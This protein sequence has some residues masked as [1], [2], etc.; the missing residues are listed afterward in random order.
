MIQLDSSTKPKSENDLCLGSAR[1]KYNP[2]L[3]GSHCP[4]TTQF[5]SD[6]TDVKNEMICDSRSNFQVITYSQ[7]QGEVTT[8]S[9]QMLY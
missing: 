7:P 5:E 6:P 2:V 4:K 8:S 9:I 3:E 1:L